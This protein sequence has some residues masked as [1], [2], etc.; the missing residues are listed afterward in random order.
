[1]INANLVVIR[2]LRAEV[3][4]NPDIA[5]TEFEDLASQ[6]VRLDLHIGHIALAP[7]LV[8]SQVFS[9]EGNEQ[10]IGLDYRKNEQQ[11]VEV[12][13]AV[14]LHEI[15]VAGPMISFQG[16]GTGGST[17]RVLARFRGASMGYYFRYNQF[18][19]AV[20]DAGMFE[21]SQVN[22]VAIRRIELNDSEF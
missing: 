5:R 10:A 11:H 15:V 8:V 6:L 13:R 1:M 2:G 16:E 3:A 21:L 14:E 19:S 7:D 12:M 18:K 9:Q 20:S 17:A 22:N 4:V